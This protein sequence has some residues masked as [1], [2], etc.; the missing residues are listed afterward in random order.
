MQLQ[1]IT[2]K[3]VLVF[4]IYVHR[5]HEILSECVNAA[6]LIIISWEY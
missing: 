4:G 2:N 6:I 3:N 1:N 5:M